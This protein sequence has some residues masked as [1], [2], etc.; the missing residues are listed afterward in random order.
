[1]TGRGTGPGQTTADRRTDHHGDRVHPL[2]LCMQKKK[3]KISV[4]ISGGA[5]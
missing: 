1:M 4:D 2:R 3:K 5:W